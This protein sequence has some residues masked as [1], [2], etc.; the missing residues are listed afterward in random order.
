[1]KQREKQRHRE[2]ERQRHRHEGMPSRGNSIG[3]PEQ[4]RVRECRVVR[5]QRP[6]T[7]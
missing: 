2:R 7:Q 5:E 3:Q 4:R 1:M 6:G